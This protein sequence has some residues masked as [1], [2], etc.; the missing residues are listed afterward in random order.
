MVLNL[1]CAE[2]ESTLIK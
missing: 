2:I 1:Q